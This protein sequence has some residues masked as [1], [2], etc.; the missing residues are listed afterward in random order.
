MFYMVK[1]KV[2]DENKSEKFIRI[3][4]NRTQRIL[5]DLRLLGNCSNTTVYNYEESQINRIFKAVDEELKRVKALFSK[6]K[7][8]SFSLK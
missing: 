1:V 7:N 4:E 6:S 8:K 5:D 3:A 2:K